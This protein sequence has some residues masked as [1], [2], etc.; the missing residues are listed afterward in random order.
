MSF[1]D[2]TQGRVIHFPPEEWPDQPGWWR[3][4]CGCCMG[5]EWGGEYPRECKTCGGNGWV[6]WHEKSKVLAWYPGG[7]FRGRDDLVRLP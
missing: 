6:A 5:L 7:P 2:S 4:D 3:L 1:W